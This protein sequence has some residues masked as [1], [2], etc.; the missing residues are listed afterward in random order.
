MDTFKNLIALV[1]LVIISCLSGSTAD[2]VQAIHRIDNF[3]VNIFILETEAAL[4]IIDTGYP[5]FEKKIIERVKSLH[6]PVR[7]IL[8]THAHYDH[9]G[10]VVPLKVFSGAKVGIH[11]A[12]S[13]SLCNGTTDLKYVKGFGY[14]GKALLP[15]AESV[16]PPQVFPP[17]LIL[18]DNDTL[19]EYGIRIRVIHTPGH[20]PGSSTFILQDSIAFVGD[21]FVTYPAFCK[22]HFYAT[23]WELID[24]SARKLLEYPFVMAITG[25]RGIT[26]DRQLIEK[27]VTF[28]SSHL[29]TENQ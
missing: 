16:L 7:L 20:T 23:S 18:H 17:D 4:Y 21:L 3:G 19:D 28:R 10:N 11:Q 14:L 26:A 2:P 5:H 1:V 29:S 9:F 8:L 25:H 27:L 13:Q 12:D 15:L 6:K 22:Q 24:S